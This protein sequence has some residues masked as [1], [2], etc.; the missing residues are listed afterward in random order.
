MEQ[1]VTR[2]AIGRM[3]VLVA[4]KI[5]LRLRWFYHHH[6]VASCVSEFV[7]FPRYCWTYS[8]KS[9]SIVPDFE[10]NRQTRA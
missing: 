5:G 9:E 4:R 2:L 8:G 6:E 7:Q 3:C 10:T 1:P